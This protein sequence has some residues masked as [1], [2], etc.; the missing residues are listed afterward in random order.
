MNSYQ[1]DLEKILDW[2]QK[3]LAK[4]KKPELADG[5]LDA[6]N[7]ILVME[8]GRFE[9]QPN[10][11]KRILTISPKSINYPACLAIWI[12]MAK[13][14]EHQKILAYHKSKFE[15]ND[16]MQNASFDILLN[17]YVREDLKELVR[18][19]G[20]TKKEKGLL[21]D[22]FDSFTGQ[23]D[24]T[25]VIK[26]EFNFEKF[27]KEKFISALKPYV[28]SEDGAFLNSIFSPEGSKQRVR[29]NLKGNQL[30][31][32]FRRMV[33]NNIIDG[34]RYSNSKIARRISDTCKVKGIRKEPWHLYKVAELGYLR[35]VLGGE[36]TP[37]DSD[38]VLIKLIPDLD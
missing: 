29:F 7:K 34:E 20:W 9:A 10:Q 14:E 17:S 23:T 27:L 11:E 25:N 28:H 33:L 24:I 32:L 35:K 13:P 37:A 31:D 4:V 15:Q 6:F 8:A 38:R 3:R 30:G 12:L 2:L 36:K 5:L 18:Q 21:L 26:L 22:N 16:L 1:I 19:L